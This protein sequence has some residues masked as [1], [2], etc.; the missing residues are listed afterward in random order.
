M[1]TAGIRRV[2]RAAVRSAVEIWAGTLALRPEVERVLWYG[3]FVTG[4]P[5]PRSDA[6]VCVVI[7]DAAPVARMPRHMRGADYAPVSVTPVPFDIAVLTASEFA[8]L[9]AWAPSWAQVLAMGEVLLAR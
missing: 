2:D 1:L 5:T 6:D 3:S 9:A 8:A 4:T 7:S